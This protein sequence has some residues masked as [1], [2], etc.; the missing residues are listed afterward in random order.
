MDRL[1]QHEGEAWWWTCFW[2]WPFRAVI[3]ARTL[4]TPLNGASLNLKQSTA[5]CNL[6][7]LSFKYSALHLHVVTRKNAFPYGMY[8]TL[9]NEA[10]AFVKRGFKKSFWCTLFNTALSAAPQIPLCRKMLV[11]NPGLLQ[12]W[13]SIVYSCTVPV[14]SNFLKSIIFFACSLL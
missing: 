14:I 13:H 6:C 1:Y 10:Y 2:N 7:I 9:E 4:H 11:F 12:I 3:T 8:G 5:V